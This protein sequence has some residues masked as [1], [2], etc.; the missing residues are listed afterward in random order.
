MEWTSKQP[1]KYVWK[2]DV[3]IK[4]P[5]YSRWNADTLRQTWHSQD[6]VQQIPFPPKTIIM[7]GKDAIN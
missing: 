1:P 5:D 4:E 6:G 3:W 7:K 2:D